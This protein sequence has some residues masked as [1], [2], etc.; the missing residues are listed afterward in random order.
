MSQ[1]KYIQDDNILTEKEAVFH[2]KT[3]P[4]MIIYIIA[5]ILNIFGIVITYGLVLLLMVLYAYLTK[6][7]WNII[8]R[9]IAQ[10]V[11]LEGIKVNTKLITKNIF[12]AKL[13]GLKFQKDLKYFIEGEVPDL[14]LRSFEV[15]KTKILEFIFT[16]TGF[17]YLIIQVY[18]SIVGIENTTDAFSLMMVPMIIAAIIPILLFWYLPIIWTVDDLK[19]R[20]VDNNKNMVPLEETVRTSIF[21]KILGVSGILLAF[22]FIKQLVEV[23]NEQTGWQNDPIA[24]T[25]LAI[26]ILIMAIAFSSGTCYLIAQLYLNTTHQSLINELRTEL[27][28]ILPVGISS[29]RHA[30]TEEMQY[31]YPKTDLIN[32][33]PSS[34][35]SADQ[36]KNHDT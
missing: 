27:S 24:D 2:V 31:F 9:N 26:L 17:S 29:V 4:T 25:F 19:I 6:K 1:A 30:T 5:L 22:D 10:K 36:D 8:G 32:K 16:N 12:L 35:Q 34:M 18:V 13:I 33:P 11:V 23:W 14:N 20:G 21:S 7:L 28:K 15:F 3:M